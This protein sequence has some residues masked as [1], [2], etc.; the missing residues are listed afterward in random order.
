MTFDLPTPHPCIWVCW[1]VQHIE[2]WLSSG[3]D[4][5]RERAILT[6]LEV[7]QFYLDSLTVKVRWR[8]HLLVSGILES[9]AIIKHM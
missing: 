3:L 2:G 4:H 8:D 9:K 7:L 1:Y 6:T 5:E